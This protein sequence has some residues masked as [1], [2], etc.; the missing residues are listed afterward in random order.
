M[1]ATQGPRS[2][3][4]FVDDEEAILD[5]LRN[6][7][8]G[9]RQRW[10]MRFAVG[11]KA[12]LE[13]LAAA[14]AEVVVTD[15]RMPGMD[16]LELLRRVREGW[17]LAARVVLSGHADL[18]AVAQAS[19]VAHRYLL[20]PC[21]AETLR[22]VVERALELQQLLVSEPVRRLAGSL[23]ALPSAPRLYQE[24]TVALADPDVK[25]KT[26]AA[27]VSQ[28][29]G[30]TARVL[31]FVNSA[32][33]GLTR[34]VTSIEESIVYV[35]ANTL[36][37]LA[38]TL[39]VLEAFSRR[40]D[41]ALAGLERHSMLTARI[42]RAIVADPS[43]A[44]AAFAAGLLHDAGKLVLKDRLPGPWDEAVEEARR[45]RR[46][47]YEVERERLGA[48]HAQV[49]AYLLGMWGLPHTIIEPVAFHH[50]EE[51]VGRGTLDTVTAV[52]AADLL[53]REVLPTETCQGST[54]PKGQLEQVAAG[55][56]AAWRALAV[57]EAQAV[58]AGA[59]PAPA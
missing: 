10:D 4:L 15:M 41:P 6:V 45:E 57:R 16:G 13:A 20:K 23:G 56:F 22:S 21:D 47:A 19:A 1:T 35:G 24:L 31:Q 18:A 3:I 44:D 29:V 37:H 30:M 34:Q 59:G 7:L 38:L 28:D 27:I 53:A 55:H 14:P 8:R 58:T 12:A 5:G 40:G 26:L 50:S 49:G 11:G 32:Y 52:T 42:A 54:D 39:E 46:P 25:V 51:R 48:D 17:P 9:E 36:R 33:Y 2:V 43:R